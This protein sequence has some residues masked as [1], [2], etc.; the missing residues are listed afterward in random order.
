MSWIR[1]VTLESMVVP[2][3][4]GIAPSHVLLYRTRAQVATW[5]APISNVAHKPVVLLYPQEHPLNVLATRVT[6]GWNH[7]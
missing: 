5:A 6:K 4:D 7:Y 2:N 1:I 3:C